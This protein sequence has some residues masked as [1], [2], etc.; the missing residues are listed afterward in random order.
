MQ[1]SIMK[2]KVKALRFKVFKEYFM[3]V[4]CGNAARFSLELGP[5]Y[6]ANNSHTLKNKMKASL[7]VHWINRHESSSS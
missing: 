3:L 4:M 7:P 2:D 5:I 6:K 1:T